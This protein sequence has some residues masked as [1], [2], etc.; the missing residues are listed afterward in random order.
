[1]WMYPHNVDMR[2]W[3]HGDLAPVGIESLLALQQAARTMCLTDRDLECIFGETARQLLRFRSAPDEQLVQQQ[4]HH[5][6]QRIPG[7]T[8][9]LS[10]R[11]E[12]FAPEK[13]PAYYEQAI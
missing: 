10:K 13:W 11:P 7:G 1:Y 9:L 5:A 8:Q 12:M 4:Y 3:P 6:R 2:S